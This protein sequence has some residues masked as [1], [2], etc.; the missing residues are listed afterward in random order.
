MEA[1]PPILPYLTVRDAR[2]AL[3]FCEAAFDGEILMIQE[4]DGA[5]NHARARIQGGIVMFYEERA[6]A[7]EGNGAP[8]TLGGS[9]V[10]IRLDLETAEAVDATFA[11]ALAAG[12]TEVV[13][14]LDRPWG[15][16]AEVRDPEGHL[17]R[18]AA[19][20]AEQ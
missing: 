17:W 5:V 15:R 2:A 18:L 16:L 4:Q 11:R 14:P 6:G 9:P 1:L 3:G 7:Y 12:A 13:A 20:A 19:S 10:A 8:A